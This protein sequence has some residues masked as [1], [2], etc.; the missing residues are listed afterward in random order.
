[1]VR[2]IVKFGSKA[3]RQKCQPIK[4]VNA[5][6][7]ALIE[8][9]FDSMRAAEGVGLAAPQIGMLKR[10]IIV[11]VSRQDPSH[12]PLALINP[13]LVKA[14]GK[15]ITEEGCLS[16]PELYGDVERHTH[17]TVEALDT[18]GEAFTVEAEGFF[19]RAL[20]HEIDHLDGK[21]FIDFISPL[22]RQLM[23]G[24]LKRLKKEG[25]QW[26]KENLAAK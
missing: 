2:D 6:I 15:E 10:V 23:R 3:L 8:D 22:K 16:F 9:L 19:A 11:D 24:A 17:V 12:L 7:E 14:E 20:Q 4:T 13:K 18:K 1:M 21:L 5:Q 26:D 25:E